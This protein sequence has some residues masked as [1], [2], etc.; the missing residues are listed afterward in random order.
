[1]GK[2]E[3][4]ISI[5]AVTIILIGLWPLG[6]TVLTCE[7]IYLIIKSII[8]FTTKT[9]YEEKEKA[10]QKYEVKEDTKKPFT[11]AD[12]ERWKQDKGGFI[13]L[14]APIRLPWRRTA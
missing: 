8:R 12:F 5:V 6:L 7:A 11:Q 13:D 4:A 9:V 1:M 10:R 2:T 14:D 3:V